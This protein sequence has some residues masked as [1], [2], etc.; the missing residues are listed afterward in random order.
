MLS[1]FAENAYGKF[2]SPVQYSWLLVEIASGL[3]K[4]LHLH[5]L[6]RFTAFELREGCC[7][8]VQKAN[9]CGLFSLFG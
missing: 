1:V 4:P 9:L 7:N 5:K 2:A 3:D 8:V 6:E